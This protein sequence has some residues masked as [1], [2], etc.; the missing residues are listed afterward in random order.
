MASESWVTLGVWGRPVRGSDPAMRR[1]AVVLTTAVLALAG[2]LTACTSDDEPTA[3]DPPEAG[4]FSVADS[5]TRLPVPDDPEFYIV[6]VADVAAVREAN[7]LEVPALDDNDALTDFLM[8]MTGTFPDAVALA[9][10]P[11]GE[12]ISSPSV[13][14]DT[15]GFSWVESD[16]F[17]AVSAPPDEFTWYAF[18]DDVEPADALDDIGDGVLSSGDGDDL[19]T[20]IDQADGASGGDRLGRPIRVG[21]AGDQAVVSLTTD[22]VAAWLDDPDGVETLADDPSMAAVADVLDDADVVSASLNHFAGDVLSTIGIGWTVTDGERG[23]VVAYDLGDDA[24]AA[25]AV[26]GAETKFADD[27]V[28]AQLDVTTVEAV[29]RVLVVTGT[30]VERVDAP[31][32]MLQNFDLPTS[33]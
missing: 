6:T 15:I 28:A 4:A 33:F 7:D 24:G 2:T 29:G 30:Q 9:Q 14:L 18:P 3:D 26:A 27:R 19:E 11:I 21:V 5:L 1:T 10:P 8:T 20:D 31:Y 13:R 25:D 23:F 32:A 22:T 17:A 16:R 12:Q